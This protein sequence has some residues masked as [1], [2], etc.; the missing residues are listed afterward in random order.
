MVSA[1]SPYSPAILSM[2]DPAAREQQAREVGRRSTLTTVQ[3]LLKVP[4]DHFA[5]VNLM[6]FYDVVSAIGPV[7]VCLNNPVQ[8]DFSGANFPAGVQTLDASQALSFV[9]QRH[10]L[11]NGD[12]D[13][14][15]DR[16]STNP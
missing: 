4:I 8:D 5:E 10:G 16:R 9:R 12:L 2:I 13:R 14:S 7:Q 6:G 15:A 3:N 1:E 11:D